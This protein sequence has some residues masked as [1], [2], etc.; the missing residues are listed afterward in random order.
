MCAPPATACCC[1]AA[2]IVALSCKV[3]ARAGA[4]EGPAR[5][6]LAPLGDLECCLFRGV[7]P[8]AITP[9]VQRGR[10]RALAVQ[11]DQS[12][13]AN[14]VKVRTVLQGVAVLRGSHHWWFSHSRNT[15]RLY[16]RW[17]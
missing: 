15:T 3:Q 12:L 5:R 13:C 6:H 10:H 11:R 17:L 7:A 14:A 8:G 2:A 16:S 9:R 1:G 4:G